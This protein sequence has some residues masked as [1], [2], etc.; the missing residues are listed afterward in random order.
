MSQVISKS[1]THATHT[2]KNKAYSFQ[3]K[4]LTVVKIIHIQV[5]I[6]INGFKYR[7]KRNSSKKGFSEDRS[8]SSDICHKQDFTV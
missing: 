1:N 2:M 7:S 3:Y 6:P 8:S 5:K 4:Y